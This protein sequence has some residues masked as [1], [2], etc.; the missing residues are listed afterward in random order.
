LGAEERH[1]PVEA[2]D[3]VQM[4]IGSNKRQPRPYQPA[5]TLLQPFAAQSGLPHTSSDA[6]VVQR[7]TLFEQPLRLLHNS[8][9]H[10]LHPRPHAK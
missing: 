3:F 5:K 10:A 1:V 8:G 4:P 7:L 2:L 9:L 6:D